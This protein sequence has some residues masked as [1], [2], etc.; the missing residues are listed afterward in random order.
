MQQRGVWDALSD[1]LASRSDD[2]VVLAMWF[3]LFVATMYFV[4]RP[5]L[6]WAKVYYS[7]KLAQGAKMLELEEKRQAAEVERD[8]SRDRTND[9]IALE[10]K[11]LHQESAERNKQMSK[12][13]GGLAP[14]LEASARAI[15]RVADLDTRL[16]SVERHVNRLL[17]KDRG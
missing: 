2:V 14:A 9:L 3:G 5:A 7:E 13:L 17:A 10:M 16:A 11:Q 12:V 6:E 1:V 4:G 8:K 15:Q